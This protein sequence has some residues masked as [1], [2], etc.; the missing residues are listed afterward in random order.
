[1]EVG[2]AAL[3]CYPVADAQ[4]LADC[5]GTALVQRP[6]PPRVE[7]RGWDEVVRGLDR[8]LFPP[9]GQAAAAMGAV[10]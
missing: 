10:A 3:A 8:L 6:A 4:A 7:V 9:A 5:I 2:G 1:M